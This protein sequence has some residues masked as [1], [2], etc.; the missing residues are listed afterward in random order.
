MGDYG[1]TEGQKTCRHDSLDDNLHHRVQAVVVN[2]E[3]CYP[4][5]GRQECLRSGKY[6]SDSMCSLYTLHSEDSGSVFTS[7]LLL[8]IC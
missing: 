3:M 2:E 8:S 6:G 1:R 4:K 7:I 5:G